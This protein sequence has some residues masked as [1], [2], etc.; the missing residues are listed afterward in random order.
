V[1]ERFRLLINLNPFTPLV[2][3]YRR[4]FLDAQAPDWIGLGYFSLI[5]LIV[6]VFGYWW[7]ARTRK[8]FADVI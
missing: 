1:P 7:F 5:A 3:C 2:R 6:F 8:S 4:I